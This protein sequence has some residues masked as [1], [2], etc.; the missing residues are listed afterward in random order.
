[1]TDTPKPGETGVEP[2]KNDA[3]ATVTPPTV[4]P[5]EIAEL[6][7]QAEQATMRANQLANQL[8]ER[9]DKEAEAERKRLE[10][11]EEWKSLAE[12]ERIKREALETEREAEKRNAE[13]KTATSE[14]LSQ[15]PAEVVELAQETGLSLTDTSDEAQTAFKEKLEKIQAKVVT[16]G[17][18]TPNNPAN[19]APTKVSDAELLKRMG[20]GDPEARRQ[21]I[22]NLP[23]VQAMRKM[24]GFQ[25]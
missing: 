6:K 3:S 20:N 16:G 18:V 24:A 2:S 23:G 9:E 4:S 13:L 21:V 5:A 11:N 8:K 12:Q 14:V 10:E 7:K 17:K 15:F 1:M 22:S 25:E 19:P